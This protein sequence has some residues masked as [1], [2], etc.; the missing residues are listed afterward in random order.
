MNSSNLSEKP[1]WFRRHFAITIILTV[2]V[3]AFATYIVLGATLLY[4]LVKN[5]YVDIEHYYYLKDSFKESNDSIMN[6]RL[7]SHQG[8]TILEIGKNGR[9]HDDF[10]AF[11]TPGWDQESL[12]AL[13]REPD[14]ILVCSHF[15]KIYGIS[16]DIFKVIMVDSLLSHEFYKLYHTPNT[17]Y[18]ISAHRRVLSVSDH[19]GNPV[20]LTE[21]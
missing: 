20:E 3:T 21:L 9:I 18:A 15:P 19:D 2:I 12:Y 14:T 16:Q 6:F 11:R 5:R 4:D 17:K 10:I 7:T 8:V 13:Y 1:N